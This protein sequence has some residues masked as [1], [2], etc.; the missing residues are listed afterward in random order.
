MKHSKNRRKSFQNLGKC[1]CSNNKKDCPIHYPIIED[2]DKG[3][4]KK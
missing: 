4:K 1:E 3:K 2:K